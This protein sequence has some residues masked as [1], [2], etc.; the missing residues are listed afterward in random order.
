M[1]IDC[2]C[3]QIY[4]HVLYPKTKQFIYL[5]FNS[6]LFSASFS[7]DLILPFAVLNKEE[8]ISKI[9]LPHQQPDIQFLSAHCSKYNKQFVAGD[10]AEPLVGLSKGIYSYNTLNIRDKETVATSDHDNNTRCTANCVPEQ[11]LSVNS[12]EDETEARVSNIYSVPDQSLARIQRSKSRQKALEFRNSGAKAKSN[13]IQK[14]V[15]LDSSPRNGQNLFASENVGKVSDLQELAE[16]SVIRNGTF[17][18]IESNEADS[19]DQEEPLAYSTVD[20]AILKGSGK[21]GSGAD[22]L[23]LGSCSGS[24]QRDDSAPVQEEELSKCVD[25]GSEFPEVTADSCVEAR[26]EDCCGHKEKDTGM[27]DG[28]ISQLGFDQQRFRQKEGPEVDISICSGKVDGGMLVQSTRQFDNANYSEEITKLSEGIV[29]ERTRSASNEKV[30]PAVPCTSTV[31]FHVEKVSY[32]RC[33][34]K[35]L[36]KNE[37][38]RMSSGEAVIVCADPCNIS[39]QL[40]NTEAVDASE[41]I[42]HDLVKAPPVNPCSITDHARSEL[43]VSETP[44][45]CLTF[46]SP[47]QLFFDD[48]EEFILDKRFSPSLENRMNQKPSS[49]RPGRSTEANECCWD[50]VKSTNEENMQLVEHGF[51]SEHPTP[52]TSYGNSVIVSPVQNPKTESQ[53]N[54]TYTK[55]CEN[56]D[57]KDQGRWNCKEL[58]KS[59]PEAQTGKVCLLFTFLY[60]FSLIRSYLNFRVS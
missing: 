39:H 23:K 8:L 7:V 16:P 5:F 34:Q 2:D 15:S 25:R 58:C 10:N 52:G 54:M 19:T 30:L 35:S 36:E 21:T 49:S 32:S 57:P 50:S 43:I 41:L 60:C 1:Q 4:L 46:L 55:H 24:I 9:L 59:T 56:S 22:S 12:P 31:P 47:K 17:G 40:T 3:L 26:A 29:L 18:V 53:T 38:Q 28:R 45:D 13:S 6:L 37:L 27:H 48:S 33:K 20:S 44:S 42:S 11:D 14:N 51:N